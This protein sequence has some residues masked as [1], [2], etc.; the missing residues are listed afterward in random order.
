MEFLNKRVFTFILGVFL[1]PSLFGQSLDTL[2]T[3]QGKILGKVKRITEFYIEYK[4]NPREDAPLYSIR[5]NQVYEIRFSDGTIEKF[6]TA[7]PLPPSNRGG[8]RNILR[9]GIYAPIFGC[10]VLSYEY[11]HS[12][13]L[14]FDFVL[15]YRNTEM[16]TF[17]PDFQ[18]SDYPM[19]GWGI[20]V[21]SKFFSQGIRHQNLF[22]AKRAITGWYFQPEIAY[23]YIRVHGVRGSF[24]NGSFFETIYSDLHGQSTVVTFSGGFQH[25]I[26]KRMNFMTQLGMGYGMRWGKFVDPQFE[27]KTS[28]DPDRYLTG[29]HYIGHYFFESG[30][31]ITGALRFGYAF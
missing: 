13:F 21:G 22:G 19:T 24:H 1:F 11:R 6:L 2:Y 18:N 25:P 12:D 16:Y 3:T 9:T 8:Y 26:G 27:E 15:G 28:R 10:V 29:I 5:K 7:D 31:A 20:K 14:A 23:T 4:K 30:L 17:P